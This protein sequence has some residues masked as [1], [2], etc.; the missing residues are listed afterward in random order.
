MKSKQMK[1]LKYLTLLVFVL[2]AMACGKKKNQI[3]DEKT[4]SGVPYEILKKGE[5]RKVEPGDVVGAR[6]KYTVMRNDSTFLSNFDKDLAYFQVQD[7]QGYGDP[8]EWLLLMNQGDSAVFYLEVDSLYRTTEP[9][10]YLQRGD[11]IQSTVVLKDVT[12]LE[13]YQTKKKMESRASME[14]ELETLK[15]ELEKAGITD[16]QV[17][18]EGLIYTIIREGKGPNPKLGDIVTLHYTGRLFSGDTFDSSYKRGEPY[19]F[20][21]GESA[22][23]KGWHIGV[24]YIREGGKATLYI[25]PSLG[26]GAEGAGSIP[27]NSPLIFDIEVLKVESAEEQSKEAV[28]KLE[29]WMKEK[30]IRAIKAPEGYYY[31]IDEKGT[32]PKPKP[33]QKV[34]VHYTGKLM[35]GTVFDSS[36]SRGE[37]IEFTLGVGQVIKGWDLGI[38]QFP[39]G[40]KGRL[41]LPPGLAYGARQTGNIPPNSP[42]I[43]EIE[44]VDAQ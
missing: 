11:V 18:D 33:G 29:S 43:F 13:E 17:T 3:P 21:V 22:V 41:F 28:K 27:P 2:S 1:R 38:Q 24:P 32:G 23:I 15:K 10:A 40:S 9:P 30:G 19:T 39:V 4:A 6:L 25:P 35:D 14:A 36:L 20:T 8:S 44:V 42:L 31:V 34:K 5:G 37:P 12:T 16:Y 7:P 26:Y